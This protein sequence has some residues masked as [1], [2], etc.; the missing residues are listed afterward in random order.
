MTIDKGR[1]IDQWH[2]DP[3]NEAKKNRCRVRAAIEILTPTNI[4]EGIESPSL[5]KAA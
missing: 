2:C 3:I 1:L 4:P 5:E